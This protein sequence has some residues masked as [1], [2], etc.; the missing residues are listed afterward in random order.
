M[1]KTSLSELCAWPMLTLCLFLA[2]VCGY[3]IG[4]I[5]D[6]NLNLPVSSISTGTGA[7]P[8]IPVVSIEGIIDGKV[9]GT[10][11]GEARLFIGKNQALPNGSGA[12]RAPADLFKVHVVH[13]KAPAGAQFVA[14]KKG[15]KYYGINS[16][17]AQSLSPENRVYFISATQAEDAGYSAGK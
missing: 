15:K 17:S 4:R 1:P 8:I 2:A 3:L 5:V 10:I 11:L 7:L 12:F 9:E 16:A 6:V 13:V 14:S